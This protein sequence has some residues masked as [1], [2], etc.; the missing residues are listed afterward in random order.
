MAALSG[1]ALR[2]GFLDTLAHQRRL[3][4]HT[5]RAYGATIDRLLAFA[6]HAHGRPADAALLQAM[7]AADWRAYLAARR[8]DGLGHASAAR[9]Q[10]ALRTFARWARERHGIAMTGL[11]SIERPRV[12]RRLPR[13]M[14]PDEAV[15]LARVTGEGHEEPWIQ[16][17]DEAVLLLL[18]GAGL[19]IGEA[20]SLT[21]AVL[22]MGETLAVEGKGR[23]TR[24]VAILPLVAQA[25]ATYARLC[26]WPLTRGDAL[27]RGAK[28]GPLDAG[29][30][31]SALRRARVA[32]G[33]PEHATPHA[34][35]HSFATH[36]L[37]RGADL[38]TIQDLLGHA[39][40]SSTQV[41]TGVDTA[42]LLDVWT[43]TH[44]RG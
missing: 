11:E 44:P 35:R 12:K 33:L 13:P 3:S 20:L 41:Y 26:P 8:A 10:S 32:L 1:E 30:L 18:Y 43:S 38:R 14:A 16:A 29:V 17:R 6:G 24:V 23:K 39:S 19:R 28:G 25:V 40:L 15:A 34:L 37:A 22:P 2:A 5:L 9:E 7:G 42:H 4:P 27:F 31:R 36:L 21:G